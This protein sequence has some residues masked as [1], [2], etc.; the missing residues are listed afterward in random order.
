[1]NVSELLRFQTVGNAPVPG[2]ED[3]EFPG[4]VQVKK[5]KKSTH[6]SSTT[7]GKEWVTFLQIV[8]S[9]FHGFSKLVFSE[10]VGIRK[11]LECFPCSAAEALELKKVS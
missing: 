8:H 11:T 1:M 9:G 2:C 10:A 4:E 6:E 3:S 5:K 7:Q